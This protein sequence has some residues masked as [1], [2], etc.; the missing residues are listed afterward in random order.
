MYVLMCQSEGNGAHTLIN[1]IAVLSYAWYTH[2]I[3]P[4]VLGLSARGGNF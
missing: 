4:V 3:A 2:S 1:T